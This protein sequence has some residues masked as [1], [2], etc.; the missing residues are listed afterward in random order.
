MKK[1]RSIAMVFV[2]ERGQVIMLDGKERLNVSS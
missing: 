1:M 2:D